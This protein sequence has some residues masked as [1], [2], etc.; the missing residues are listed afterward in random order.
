MM[1]GVTGTKMDSFKRKNYNWQ[2]WFAP[3]NY[4]VRTIQFIVVKVAAVLPNQRP[5]FEDKKYPGKARR[6][7]K[8][9]IR[10]IEENTIIKNA[11]ISRPLG[12]GAWA[13][14]PIRKIYDFPKRKKQPAKRASVKL[15][16][17]KKRKKRRR[18]RQEARIEG[19]TVQRLRYEK[20]LQCRKASSAQPQ[21]EPASPET[22][23]EA[24]QMMRDCIK[25]GLKEIE[26][27]DNAKGEGQTPRGKRTRRACSLPPWRLPRGK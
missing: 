6:K 21:S 12:G 3:G 11:G 10:F 7:W 24:F 5:V 22:P 27:S 14:V 2:T 25:E 15:G 16:I 13:P 8:D 18:E 1:F 4:E 9:K 19:L 17:I 26:E 20:S 23:S